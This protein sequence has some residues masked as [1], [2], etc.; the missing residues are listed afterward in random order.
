MDGNY[1]VAFFSSGNP[2]IMMIVVLATSHDAATF[3][4]GGGGSVTVP[5]L[6]VLTQN[7]CTT[8]HSTVGRIFSK[9]ECE[10]DFFIEIYSEIFQMPS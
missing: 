6:S 4:L 3:S 2:P 7:F 5:F 8:F 9:F 10:T 1:I